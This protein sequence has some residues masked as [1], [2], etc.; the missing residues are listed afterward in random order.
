[1]LSD[2]AWRVTTMNTTGRS[3]SRFS[4]RFLL[5]PVGAFS[6]TESRRAEHTMVSFVLTPEHAYPFFVVIAYVLVGQ[7]LG[8]LV[9]RARGKFGIKVPN[10]YANAAMFLKDGKVDEAAMAARGDAFNRVQRG[11]QHMFEIHA[12]AYALL[13]ASSILYPF[14]AAVAGATFFFFFFG[15]SSGA[16]YVAGTLAYGLGYARANNARLV[17]E[18]LYLPALLYMIYL[19]GLTGWKLLH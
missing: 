18:V 10:L 7:V 13:F 2:R 15:S 3:H 17:G 11:H 1:V 4:F 12:D 19:V 5:F 14:H 9:N 6:L 16:F 8:G